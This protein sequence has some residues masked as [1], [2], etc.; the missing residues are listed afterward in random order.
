MVF[1]SIGYK[2]VGIAGL[3][4]DEKKGVIPNREG[5]VVEK[6]ADGAAVVPGVYVSGWV[7]RGPSGVIGTNRMD[8]EETVSSLCADLTEGKLPSLQVSQ[9]GLGGIRPLLAARGAHVVDFGGWKK[10]EVEEEGRGKASG[11]ER[12]KITSVAEMLRLAANG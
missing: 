11:T 3:P 12:T 6:A 8:A 4:F 10:L 2:S 1:R 5:R 7:K 9:P